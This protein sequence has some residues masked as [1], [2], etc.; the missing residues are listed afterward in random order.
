[1]DYNTIK[2]ERRD[3]IGIL[4]LNRPERL[5]AMTLEMFRELRDVFA[6]LRDDLQTRVIVLRGEGRGFCA[7][8]DL[9]VMAAGVPGEGELGRVQHLYHNMQEA[10]GD[11]T[12][13][14]RRA[15]QPVIA[16][17]RGPAVGGGLSL[18]LACDVRIAGESA[19]FNAAFIRIGLSAGDMGASYYLPRL[20]GLSRAAE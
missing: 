17:V 9:G 19:R 7:G 18:S 10:A 6:R 8:F 1:M 12:I 15:P 5:N 20:I 13:N 3:R 16:A 11:I 4:S 2:F 14:M